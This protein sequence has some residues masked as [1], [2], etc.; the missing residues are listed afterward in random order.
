MAVLD[1]LTRHK[2]NTSHKKP[3]MGYKVTNKNIASFTVIVGT[4]IVEYNTYTSSNVLPH[5][6]D[7]CLPTV[8]L[9][10]VLIP[11]INHQ[12]F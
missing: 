6:H 3:V 5:L 2:Q 12:T 11:K 1:K 9:T 8:I 7:D 10:I 4:Y